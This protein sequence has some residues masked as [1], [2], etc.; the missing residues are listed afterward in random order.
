MPKQNLVATWLSAIGLA[1]QIVE[2]FEAAGIVQPKDLAELEVC[3]YPA[4]GVKDAAD[5][6]KLFYLIQRV[7]MAVPDDDNGSSGGGSGSG[8]PNALV[9]ATSSD[10][11]DAGERTGVD[12]TRAESDGQYADSFEVDE[13]DGID[14]ALQEQYKPLLRNS[15]DEESSFHSA[16]ADFTSDE[17]VPSPPSTPTRQD[18]Y[19]TDAVSPS[20]SS[21]NKREEEF[22]KRRN[23][24][25]EKVTSP[26]KEVPKLEKSLK[27]TPEKNPKRS[28]LK[29]KVA[30]MVRSM[31]KSPYKRM[32]GKD[33][34]SAPVDSPDISFASK[35]SKS[36]TTIT[37][38][39]KT[40]RSPN[41]ANTASTAAPLTRREKLARLKKPSPSDQQPESAVERRSGKPSLDMEPII[42]PST[43]N[44]GIEAP[45]TRRRSSRR[46]E[47]K[48]STEKSV[49]KTVSPTSTQTDAEESFES[50]KSAAS[51]RRSAHESTASPNSSGTNST[52][53][54]SNEGMTANRSK[55]SSFGVAGTA[56]TKERPSKLQNPTARD[57]GT[58][59]LS[60]IPSDRA[61][62]M[63]PLQ[64]ST[65]DGSDEIDDILGDD[66]VSVSSAV[67]SAS[68]SSKDARKPRVRL[69]S[70]G[71]RS[72]KSTSSSNPRKAKDTKATASRA[73]STPRGRP[74][75]SGRDS[76]PIRSVPSLEMLKSKSFENVEKKDTV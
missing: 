1:P 70:V 67:S 37:A 7:K 68:I 48:M 63:S 14:A 23:A 41:A 40:S 11:Q 71:D 64:I 32:V 35:S 2:T 73:K 20:P 39:Y 62:I 22:L 5:R 21:R 59:R 33:Q 57:T 29:H 9:Q 10:W 42:K 36:S 26:R 12:E 46:L 66:A 43:S 6:K 49:A 24:R 69:S 25:L 16:D 30:G 54:V 27:D 56:V 52:T 53:N 44:A 61:A 50:R 28:S 55:K 8:S 74:A 13:D 58:S 38:K 15:S 65:A 18:A 47:E 51:T 19:T 17:D 4:L 60:T 45:A 31:N 76:P 34:P 75:V 72:A 3:H